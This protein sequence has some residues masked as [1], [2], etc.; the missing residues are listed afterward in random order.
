MPLKHD[1]LSGETSRLCPAPKLGVF[2]EEK[3]LLVANYG[4]A[5]TDYCATVAEL[6]KAMIRD[7]REVYA[8]RRRRVEV[9][10]IICEAALKELDDHV[11]ADGC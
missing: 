8:E 5:V 9:A 11:S 1:S 10:R 4:A 3:I 6:E 2:C 7:S